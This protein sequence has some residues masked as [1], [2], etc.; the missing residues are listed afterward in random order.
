MLRVVSLARLLPARSVIGPTGGLATL[1][2]CFW[3]LIAVLL[4]IH[5]GG[6]S[7]QEDVDK[8]ALAARMDGL[9]E[10]FMTREQVPGAIAAVVSGDAVILRGYGFSDLEEGTPVDPEETRF[11]IGSISK[12]FT[13]VAVMMLV[14]EGDLDLRAD[15]S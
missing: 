12:L 3:L 8:A 13:W 15:I 10:G 1:R 9:A 11:E 14:E 2:R 7:A 6:A 5:P 4:C